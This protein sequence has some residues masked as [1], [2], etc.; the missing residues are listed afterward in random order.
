MSFYDFRD[1]REL[2]RSQAVALKREHP[3]RTLKWLAGKIGVQSTYLT[4]VLKGR[5]HLNSDQLYATVEAFGWDEDQ[6][7]YVELLM[8]WERSA[9]TKRKQ[10]LQKRIDE[11]RKA[12]LQSKAHLKQEVVKANPEEYSKFYLNPFYALV[13]A[14]ITLP[15]YAS[16]PSLVSQC[17]N[18]GSKQVKGIVKELVQLHFL[19]EEKGAYMRTKKNFHLPKESPLCSPHLL[20]MQ[21]AAATHMQSLPEE[22]KYSF[23]ATLS[24]DPATREKIHREFLNFLKTIEPWVKAAP[25]EELYGM[26]FDLFRW[27]FERE[28]RN[29]TQ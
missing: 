28:E 26:R 3:A 15:K 11:V 1:Y 18:L 5:S 22:E 25:V 10:E 13:H 20:L 8:D 24:A 9:H 7:A 6:A 2:I 19:A 27:S 16:K 21:Q 4:N 23:T 12:K 29:S 17:L 14:F